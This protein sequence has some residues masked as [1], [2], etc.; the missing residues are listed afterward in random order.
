MIYSWIDFVFPVIFGY[1]DSFKYL[2]WKKD[3]PR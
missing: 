1:I 2:N 3:V